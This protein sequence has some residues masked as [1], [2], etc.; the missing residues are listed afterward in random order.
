MKSDGD[1]ASPVRGRLGREDHPAV[2]R[3]DLRRSRTMNAVFDT[4]LLAP[5]TIGM[6]ALS[7]LWPDALGYSESGG[8]T[9]L[10]W[11]SLAEPPC[12]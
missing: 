12:G 11:G 8:R 4:L 2:T 5:I 3:L 6:A 10:A 7:C 1:Q 9:P